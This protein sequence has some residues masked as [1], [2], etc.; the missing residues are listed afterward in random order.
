MPR[1]AGLLAGIQLEL[2]PGQGLAV[3]IGLNEL[4]VRVVAARHP[5]GQPDVVAHLVD[6]SQCAG[7]YPS[8]A[9][10]LRCRCQLI[11]RRVEQL[12]EAQ[13][14]PA[15]GVLLNCISQVDCAAF[16]DGLAVGVLRRVPGHC[17]VVELHRY[18]EALAHGQFAIEGGGANHRAVLCGKL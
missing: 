2:R 5:D 3:L 11:G 12:V 4:E 7:G 8:A 15:I 18:C 13:E 9:A 16:H 17:V 1:A 14:Q 6:I 10:M